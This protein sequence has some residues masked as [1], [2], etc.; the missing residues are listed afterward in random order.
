MILNLPT[1]LP[2][3]L[4]LVPVLCLS[5]SLSLRFS[6]FSWV[7]FIRTRGR[8]YTRTGSTVATLDSS[9]GTRDL[10]RS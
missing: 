2:L 5:L 9:S 1:P 4:T 10:V 6:A 3:S 8:A 7:Y